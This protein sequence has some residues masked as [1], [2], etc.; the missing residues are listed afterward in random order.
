MLV[1]YDTAVKFYH[2]LFILAYLTNI[3]LAIYF[4]RYCVFI[5]FLSIPP[6]YGLN[7]NLEKE[8]EKSDENTA[9][10]HTMFGVLMLIGLLI[11]Y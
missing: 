9:K 4:K 10:F 1:G 6:A 7:K 3:F 11:G 5:T 8:I 2:S